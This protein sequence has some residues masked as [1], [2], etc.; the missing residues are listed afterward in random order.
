[1]RGLRPV[2]ALHTSWDPA[3]LLGIA[4]ADKRSLSPI[5]TP[6]PRSPT[7]KL[8][9]YWDSAYFRDSAYI[10]D[11]ADL[12]GVTKIDWGPATSWGPLGLLGAAQSRSYH[13][14]DIRL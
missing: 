10:W 6:P 5:G 9:T 14:Q 2:G 11:P 8:Q 3:D 13:K 12:L 4:Q 7:G 1:M